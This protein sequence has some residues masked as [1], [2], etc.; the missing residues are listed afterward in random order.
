MSKKLPKFTL[1]YDR[2]KE[3]WKLENDKSDQVVKRFETKSDATEGGALK[4]AVGTE[5]GSVRIEKIKGGY[6]EE[7]TFPRS[8][9][10]KKT[11]G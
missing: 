4:K 11:K 5:G 2:K 1:S 7:R 10:P 6:Q 3:D 9:D 8:A